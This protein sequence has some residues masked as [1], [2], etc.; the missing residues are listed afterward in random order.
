M[1]IKCYEVFEK[2]SNIKIVSAKLSGQ[3][4]S[5]ELIPFVH[6]PISVEYD[7]EGIET[8]RKKGDVLYKIRFS[9]K[10]EGTY[11]L[12]ITYSNS[13]TE[14]FEI[15]ASGY[16]DK[17][18]VKVSDKDKRY[19][20]Y[21]DGTSYFP[22]G[23][24]L[25]F[26]ESYGVTSGKEFEVLDYKKFVGIRQYERWIKSC[27]ESGVN[28][29]R[30]WLGCD[31]FSP[32]TEDAEIFRYEQYT[33]LDKIV[34]I[35]KKYGVKLKLTIE[36]FRFFMYDL[37]K[38]PQIYYEI[39]NK[40]LY[41]NGERCES[42]QDW[43]ANSK[44][45]DSWINKVKQLAARYAHDT[46]IFA[47]ELWN[48]MYFGTKEWNIEMFKRVG[49]LFPNTLVINSLGSL[50]HDGTF[51]GYQTFPWEQSGF[52]QLHRYLDQG[53]KYEDTT[54]N[55]ID[56]ILKGKERVYDKNMPLV[57]AETGAVNNCH[58][59]PFKFYVNDHDG[60]LFVDLVYTPVFSEFASCGHIWHWDSS[61]VESKNLYKFFKPM[62]DLVKDVNFSDEKFEFLDLS[63]DEMYILFLKGKNTCLCFVRN[64]DYNWQNVLRDCKVPKTILQKYID[65]YG[66][67]KALTYKIWED[68]LTKIKIVNS[69]I[70]IENCNRG[71]IFRLK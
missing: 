1:I 5:E 35:A 38:T 3:E 22:I 64:K 57:L 48:E 30:L 10:K 70:L 27:S 45:R 40:K 9:V 7:D 68:D 31:Y 50:D 60:I 24:N 15:T 12:L 14:E 29:I 34:E 56:L 58:S 32:D 2:T 66:F 8:L 44:W 71:I 36:H 23:I 51:W 13:T 16:L 59:G 42:V 4:Y 55:P 52:K 37:P 46:S 53:G 33:K 28:L 63:D 11:K 20:E 26:P 62:A 65:A 39:F 49:K 54:K 21:E 18:F 47:I 41:L 69:K 17:G 67:E 6:Q 25:C 43:M 61:Y 19:F